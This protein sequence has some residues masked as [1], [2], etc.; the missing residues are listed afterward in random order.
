MNA[1][2]KLSQL[3]ELPWR[4][5]VHAQ[6]HGEFDD[7]LAAFGFGDAREGLDA[8]VNKRKP[9]RRSEFARF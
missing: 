8:Y 6:I 1:L 5:S 2:K 9:E 4:K 3:L 7:A